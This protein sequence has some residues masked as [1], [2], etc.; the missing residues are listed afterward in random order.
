MPLKINGAW[1]T[2]S[3]VLPYRWRHLSVTVATMRH[4]DFKVSSV[5][6][7]SA[8]VLRT[9]VGFSLLAMVVVDLLFYVHGKHLRSCRDGQL[10]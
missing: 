10:T 5:V 9:A 1:H 8:K 3:T 6:G 4:T 2:L 7:H